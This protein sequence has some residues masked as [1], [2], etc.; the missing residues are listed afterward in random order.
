M[1]EWLRIGTN[2]ATLPGLFGVVAVLLY[3][4]YRAYL[5]HRENQLEKL[6]E[7]QRAR[8]IDDLATR[9]GV[10]GSNLTKEQRHD[11][12]RRDQDNK[13]TRFRLVAIVF[14]FVVS[15]VAILLAIYFYR[16]DLPSQTLTANIVFQGN[17]VHK[18]FTLTFHDEAGRKYEASGTDGAAK[19]DLPGSVRLLKS[20]SVEM[21]C[22]NRKDTGAIEIVEGKPVTIELDRRPTKKPDHPFIP[23]KL[24]DLLTL[25]PMK[26]RPTPEQ[27]KVVPTIRDPGQAVLESENNT[28]GFIKLLLY[29]FDDKRTHPLRVVMSDH[30]ELKLFNKFT[31]SI[32]W[33]AFFAQTEA[34]NLHYLGCTDVYAQLRTRV[35]LEKRDNKVVGE[36]K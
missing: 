27:L 5:K 33:F 15:L 36:F 29:S 30:C 2:I 22:Y 24:P 4:G 16:P 17:L 21:P 3:F 31:E 13:L 20:V 19:I 25:V 11:L 8:A 14:V 23:G 6:P 28:D 32:G 9:Y 18:K 10:E 35:I 12:I 34:G 7:D 1:A 26:D